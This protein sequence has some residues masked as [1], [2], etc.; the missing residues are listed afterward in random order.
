MSIEERVREALHRDGERLTL[1]ARPPVVDLIRGG[2]AGRG[3]AVVVGLAV[4]VAVAAVVAALAWLRGPS[5]GPTVVSS[6]GA[7]A[8]NGGL[9]ASIAAV[10]PARVMQHPSDLPSAP[11]AHRSPPPALLDPT[12]DGMH[13]VADDELVAGK[14]FAGEYDPHPERDTSLTTSTTT[15]YAR[16]PW[17]TADTWLATV[18]VDGDQSALCRRLGWTATTPAPGTPTAPPVPIGEG[19]QPQFAPPTQPPPTPRAQPAGVAGHPA[20]LLPAD[21]SDGDTII[22]WM[23]QHD[24]MLQVIGHGLDTGQILEAAEHITLDEQKS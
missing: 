18:T 11:T 22:L 7:A 10:C 14:S 20:I 21:T 5:S 6:P 12:P 23:P 19:E 1:P 3:V 4:V 9:L 2:P 24:R 13:R 8:S 17:A 15:L 16:G